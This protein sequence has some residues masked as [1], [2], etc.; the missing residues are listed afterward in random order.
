M[1]RSSPFCDAASK[2]VG[3]TRLG[4]SLCCIQDQERRCLVPAGLVDIVHHRLTKLL[5]RCSHAIASLQL[6]N[7][8]RNVWLVIYFFESTRT[9]NGRVSNSAKINHIDT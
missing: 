6:D 8:H 3:D 7:E 2:A 1:G 5:Y 4:V 9:I